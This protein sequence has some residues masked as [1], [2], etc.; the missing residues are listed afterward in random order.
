MIVRHMKTGNDYIVLG[1]IIDST[2]Y[3]N[4]ATV[5][6]YTRKNLCAK[7]LLFVMNLVGVTMYVRDVEEFEEKFRRY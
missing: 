2:N 6:L 4:G 3:R 5:I 7:F 1:K